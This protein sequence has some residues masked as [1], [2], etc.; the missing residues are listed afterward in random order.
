MP[1]RFDSLLRHVFTE[2][3]FVRICCDSRTGFPHNEKCVQEGMV[4]ASHK[5]PHGENGTMTSKT[6]KTK[7][8]EGKH[9]EGTAK[10]SSGQN[11]TSK[12]DDR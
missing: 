5:V 4:M 6:G 3:E 11:Q 12:L 9:R 2:E 7:N 1:Q 8:Y 10:G